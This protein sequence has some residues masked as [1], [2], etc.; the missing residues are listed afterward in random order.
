V[1]RAGIGYL[2]AKELLTPLAIPLHDAIRDYVA[3]RPFLKEEPLLKP[4]VL[5]GPFPGKL[6][7]F[8]CVVQ[9]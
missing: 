5:S 6:L 7:D 1:R 3:A 4:Q 2:H 9:A 8:G